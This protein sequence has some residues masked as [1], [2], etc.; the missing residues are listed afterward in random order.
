MSSFLLKLQVNLL[1]SF[2]LL[3]PFPPPIKRP[4]DYKYSVIF[5]PSGTTT[6]CTNCQHLHLPLNFKQLSLRF[7]ALFFSVQSYTFLSLCFT[8]CLTPNALFTYSRYH[9]LT[10][11]GFSILGRLSDNTCMVTY[12]FLL[13]K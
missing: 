1:P 12:I 4:D 5:M 11:R 2:H 3:L 13:K 9:H 8:P 10:F 7:P 6:L